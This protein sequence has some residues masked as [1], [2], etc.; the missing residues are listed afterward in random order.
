MAL[1]KAKDRRKAKRMVITAVAEVSDFN[2]RVVHEGYV[3]NVSATGVGVFLLKPLR[4]GS[5]VEV[6]L[7]FYAT[8]GIGDARQIRGIVKRVEMF[9]NV[10]NTGIEFEHLDPK[11]D[12]DLIQYLSLQNAL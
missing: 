4:V 9:N 6:K 5:R 2:S 11:K 1:T 8:D 3:A 10:Y 12:A 7:S